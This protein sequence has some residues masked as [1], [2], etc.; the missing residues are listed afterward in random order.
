MTPSCLCLQSTLFFVLLRLQGGGCRFLRYNCTVRENKVGWSLIH[1][2]RLTHWHE[3]LETTKG[4]RYILVSF[5]DPW[6]PSGKRKVMTDG[7]SRER[8]LDPDPGDGYL[9]Q[10]DK[11][12]LPCRIALQDCTADFS[13]FWTFQKKKLD[14]PFTFLHTAHISLHLPPF[15]VIHC[16]LFIIERAKKNLIQS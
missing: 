6:T 16:V 10:M 11:L 5:I 15:N 9:E 2:G 12:G 3:G 4:T 7:S 8:T 14:A 1:P 13:P